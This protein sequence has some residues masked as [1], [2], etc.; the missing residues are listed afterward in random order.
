MPHD[1][2]DMTLNTNPILADLLAL[3]AASLPAVGDILGRAKD[4]VRA[5][6]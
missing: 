4:A 3:T 2:Q 5:V 1:G 6:V